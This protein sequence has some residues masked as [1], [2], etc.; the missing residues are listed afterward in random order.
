MLLFNACGFE[1]FWWSVI[2]CCS[3]GESNIKVYIE[4]SDN[5]TTEFEGMTKISITLYSNDTFED[6]IHS[7]TCCVTPI[8][9]Q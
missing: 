4:Y 1:H 6:P 9:V 2:H 8:H 5:S 3:S 7:P